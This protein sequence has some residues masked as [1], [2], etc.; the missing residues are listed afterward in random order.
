MAYRKANR[1]LTEEQFSEGTTIDGSR[2]DKAI[3]DI[4]DNHNNIQTGDMEARWMPN[5]IT[6]NWQ[7]SNNLRRC[8]STNPINAGSARYG[9]NQRDYLH[10]AWFPFLVSRNGANEVFPSNEQPNAFQ[11]EYRTKGYYYNPERDKADDNEGRGL[12]I[13]ASFNMPVDSNDVNP[14][15]PVAQLGPTWQDAAAPGPGIN[16]TVLGNGPSPMHQKYFTL[17]IPLYFKK[18]IIITNVSVFAASE[19]PLGAYNSLMDIAA[20]GVNWAN[21]CTMNADGY[22]NNGNIA[23]QGNYDCYMPNRNTANDAF[24]ASPDQLFSSVALAGKDEL[25][26]TCGFEM[27]G[28]LYTS[29]QRNIGDG[30]I[31]IIQDNEFLKEKRQLNN[32]IFNKTG[33]SDSVY[34]FNRFHTTTNRNYIP[35]VNPLGDA[36]GAEYQD[37]SPRFSGGPTWGI[38]IKED[39]LNIPVSRD[40]RLRFCVTTKGYRSSL[41]FDWHIALTFLEQVED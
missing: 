6:A 24:E 37:M 10:Q 2:I 20:P 29:T 15:A 38:W 3:D 39:G 30:T 8:M 22:K 28:D 33:F 7:P 1:H 25:P 34:R 9:F 19:H 32:V 27:P 23:D 16:S 11:N 4:M 14:W 40:S 5:T 26:S 12:G 21:Q 13:P 35:N 31:Q 17:T 18:P 41:L 36:N